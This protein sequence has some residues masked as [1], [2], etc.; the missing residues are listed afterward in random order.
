MT[1]HTTT[2][3]IGSYVRPICDKTLQLKYLPV[4][5]AEIEGNLENGNR[6]YMQNK[7]CSLFDELV[8]S[9]SFCVFINLIKEINRKT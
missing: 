3:K 2:L 7:P 4:G 5:D 9:Q 1:W 6:G 8:K